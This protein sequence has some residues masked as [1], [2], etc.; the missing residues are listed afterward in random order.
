MSRDQIYGILMLVGSLFR[1]DYINQL[2]FSNYATS[3]SMKEI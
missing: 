3:K 2:R 1:N